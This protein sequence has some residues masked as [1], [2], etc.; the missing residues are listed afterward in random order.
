MVKPIKFISIIYKNLFYQWKTRFQMKFSSKEFE[1]KSIRKDLWLIYSILW[2]RK[3]SNI[4]HVPAHFKSND[5]S[6]LQTSLDETFSRNHIKWRNLPTS[7]SSQRMRLNTRWDFINRSILRAIKRITRGHRPLCV[8]YC[9]AV[10]PWNC[11]RVW[12]PKQPRRCF[13]RPRR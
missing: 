8:A 6:H 11:S 10:K 7:S 12:I 3:Q 13:P 1:E 5:W 9:L 2:K 4:R